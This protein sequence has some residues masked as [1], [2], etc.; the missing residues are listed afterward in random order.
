MF[1]L[2]AKIFYDVCFIEL[3]KCGNLLGGRLGLN[4]LNQKLPCGP[5]QCESEYRPV[6]SWEL[7]PVFS[8]E[9]HQYTAAG[10]VDAALDDRDSCYTWSRPTPIWISV[11]TKAFRSGSLILLCH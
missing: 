8:W 2:Y 9:L 1:S 10:R 3:W 11:I 7:H 5:V 4:L 6:F